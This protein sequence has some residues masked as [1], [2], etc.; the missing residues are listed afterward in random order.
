MEYSLGIPEVGG[1]LPMISLEDN[2]NLCDFRVIFIFEGVLMEL[3]HPIQI[4]DLGPKNDSVDSKWC[5][6]LMVLD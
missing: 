1:F 4:I 2:F 3:A 6:Q 5:T